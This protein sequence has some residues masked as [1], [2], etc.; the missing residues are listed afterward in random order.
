MGERLIVTPALSEIE[1]LRPDKSGL[2]MTEEIIKQS[3]WEKEVKNGH[4]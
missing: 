2:K 4:S 3:G 1:I